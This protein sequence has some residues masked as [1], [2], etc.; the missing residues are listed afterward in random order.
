MFDRI[1]SCRP[2][3]HRDIVA[4]DSRSVGLLDGAAA[5]VH[6]RG[7]DAVRRAVSAVS[8]RRS[9]GDET[10]AQ[11]GSGTPRRASSGPRRISQRS[12]SI[13]LASS[14]AP[15]LIQSPV[16]LADFL[17][18]PLFKWCVHDRCSCSWKNEVSMLAV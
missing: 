11:D 4:R 16:S 9:G 3:L 7:R 1:N 5:E 14:L 10:A 12:V 15:P 17:A 18:K 2:R 6:R 8:G 13:I